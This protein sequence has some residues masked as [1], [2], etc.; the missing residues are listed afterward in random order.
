MLRNSLQAARTLGTFSLAPLMLEE[1]DKL[2]NISFE[3]I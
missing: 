3:Q 1:I 2:L